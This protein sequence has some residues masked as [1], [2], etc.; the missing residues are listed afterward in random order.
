MQLR[1]DASGVTALLTSVQQRW[2]WAGGFLRWLR[3]VKACRSRRLDS[4]A[5]AAGVA[6]ADADMPRKELAAPLDEKGVFRLSRRF[7]SHKVRR[8]A[9]S[10][11]SEPEEVIASDAEADKDEETRLTA[12]RVSRNPCTV[13]ERAC[14]RSGDTD[15]RKGPMEA[16]QAPSTVVKASGT[17]RLRPRARQ[18]QLRYIRPA[19]PERVSS[20]GNP[21]TQKL[22]LCS[23]CGIAKYCGR[24]CQQTG[25]DTKKVRAPGAAAGQ[26]LRP[27]RRRE[28]QADSHRAPTDGAGR[29]KEKAREWRGWSE[30]K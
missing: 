10:E 19:L 7:W 14:P 28:N 8:D 15:I 3:R 20:V 21:A 23:S 17:L 18:P 26:G 11:T 1:E 6:R 13:H 25:S 2:R 12:V 24:D 22:V 29:R 27:Q 9:S 5:R 16:A 4:S 30:S